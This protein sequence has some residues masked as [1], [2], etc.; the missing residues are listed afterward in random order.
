MGNNGDKQN[1]KQCY[2]L[3]GSIFLI[4]NTISK[5]LNQLEILKLFFMI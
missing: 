4:I 2:N 5:F 1:N 3:L